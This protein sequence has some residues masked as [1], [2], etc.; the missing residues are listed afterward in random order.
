MQLIDTNVNAILQASPPAKTQAVSAQTSLE[1]LSA[2]S[3]SKRAP[4]SSGIGST[5]PTESVEDY[6]SKDKQKVIEGNNVQ[7]TTIKAEEGNTK[8]DPS[9]EVEDGA[10][11]SMESLMNKAFKGQTL[12]GDQTKLEKAP[13]DDPGE[14]EDDDDDDVETGSS[15]KSMMMTGLLN[16]ALN[17]E[18]LGGLEPV[19]EVDEEKSES[20]ITSARDSDKTASI[21][22]EET[23]VEIVSNNP[24]KQEAS[25]GRGG[26]DQLK[27]KEKAAEKEYTSIQEETKIIQNKDNVSG[28][29]EDKTEP[30]QLP[31]GL[32]NLEE[33]VHSL[34]NDFKAMVKDVNEIKIDVG[35]I[36][37]DVKSMNKNLKT[38][39]RVIKEKLR[40]GT[41]AS[42]IVETASDIDALIEGRAV[43]R[44]ITV[45]MTL[46]L[47]MI[48]KYFSCRISVTALDRG[49]FK[50]DSGRQIPGEFFFKTVD[51][52]LV[53][54]HILSKMGMHWN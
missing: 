13:Q 20:A 31:R 5:K 48:T 35:D 27:K 41:M 47:E 30:S 52:N 10:I 4:D 14:A 44:E 16:M 11:E 49:R 45:R 3:P 19:D 9:E 18:L 33:D 1:L 37:K 24:D 7:Q 12:L 29:G 25:E 50:V 46:F 21:V 8:E 51:Q 2:E 38:D 22:E 42:S 28:G 23:N 36:K 53:A 43:G 34:K 40:E 32:K 17:S 15:S 39:L 54:H 6:E 26:E